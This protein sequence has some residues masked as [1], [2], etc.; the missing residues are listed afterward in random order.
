MHAETSLAFS[1]WQGR[2]VQLFWIDHR[3]IVRITLVQVDPD[4][5]IS[6]GAAMLPAKLFLCWTFWD[7]Q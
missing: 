5:R 2:L 4:Q 1:C 3:V 6:V 7:N